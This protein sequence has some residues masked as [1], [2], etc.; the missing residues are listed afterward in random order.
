MEKVNESNEEVLEESAEEINDEVK[1]EEK[2]EEKEVKIEI[3]E[4][5]SELEVLQEEVSDSKDKYLRLQAEFQNYK[6]RVEK[7]RMDLIKYSHGEVIKDILP[8][9]D[10]FERAIDSTKDSE[11]SESLIEGIE[12]IKKSFDEFLENRKIEVVKTVGEKFDTK[13]HHAV[14]KEESDKHEDNEIIQELQKGYIL[15]GKVL[16]YAM[17]KVAS[18]K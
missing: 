12:L 9:I 10:N 11:N 4:E 6:K 16:R 2:E 15:E 17:V 13:F 18:N 7:Q 5:K 8:I 3:V 1:E 14:M